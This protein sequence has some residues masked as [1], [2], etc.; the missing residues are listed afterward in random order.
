M[1]GSP[2]TD[3]VKLFNPGNTSRCRSANR[4]ELPW[5]VNWPSF[6][7]NIGMEVSS[8][9]VNRVSVEKRIFQMHKLRNLV[10]QLIKERG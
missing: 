1:L 8:S 4:D 9:E 3:V 10:P 7:I 2:D 6:S 5:Y